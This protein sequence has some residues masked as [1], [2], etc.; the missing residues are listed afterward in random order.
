MLHNKTDSH[1]TFKTTRCL[2]FGLFGSIDSH[3]ILGAERWP[4]SPPPPLRDVDPLLGGAR[5]SRGLLASPG[6]HGSGPGTSTFKSLRWRHSLYRSLSE[7]R[8]C[9]RGWVTITHSHIINII[10]L[11]G[12]AGARSYPPFWP[13]GGGYLCATW[14]CSIPGQELNHHR[15]TG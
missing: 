10:S 14:P 11:G 12:G 15:H 5:C 7:V 9:T 4:P 3:Q 2:P 8:R 1:S 13:R 6:P